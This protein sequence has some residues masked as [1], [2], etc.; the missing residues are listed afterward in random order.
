MHQTQPQCRQAIWFPLQDK[1][2]RD[3]GT[4]DR[5][6]KTTNYCYWEWVSY[7]NDCKTEGGIRECKEA[8]LK[9]NDRLNKV[10][11]KEAWKEEKMDTMRDGMQHTCFMMHQ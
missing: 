8:S 11:L 2:W 10:T 7:E 5:E 9:T 1:R 6:C 3:Y 4:H